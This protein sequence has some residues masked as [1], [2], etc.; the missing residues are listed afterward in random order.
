MSITIRPFRFTP[1]LSGFAVCSV[2]CGALFSP[3]LVAQEGGEE[4]AE[5]VLEVVMVTGSRIRRQD[6]VS[7]SP[8][9]T[10]SEEDL[11]IDGSL[12][13]GE[14]LQHLPSVGSSLNSNG[15]AGTSH[16]ARS[17]NLRSLGANRSLV[18][19][20]GHRWVNGAG[21]RGF[22]DFVDLNTIPQVMIESVEVLQDGASAIYG[23][24]AIAGVVNMRTY[25]NF[26]GSRVRAYYGT[27]SEADRDTESADLLLGKTFGSSNWMLAVSYLNED[28]IFTQDRKL[29]AIPL[30]GLSVGTPEG[31]FREAGLAGILPFPVPSAGITR[32]PGTDGSVISNW[33]AVN[34]STDRFNRFNN[35]Y[36]VA[37]NELTSVFLQNLTEFN[38]SVAFRLEALYNK[39]ESD[40][41]FSGAAPV[42]LGGSRGFIIANDPRVNPFG[43]PFAG[44]DFRI[45][46]FF[47][48]NGQRD[49]VQEV[50]T[51]R[52]GA[53]LEGDLAN[54][55]FWDSF[56]SYAKNEATFT[57]INQID[58]DKL[59]LG[60]RACD[61]TGITT[62]ITDL[63]AGCVP[64]NM[65]NPWTAEM[66]NYVNFTGLDENEAEQLD[67]TLNITGDITELPAGSL[68]F[69]A[70]YE[71]RKE[72][73]LDVPDSYINGS[74]RVNTFRT[75]TS[76]PRDGT[77]G[78]YDLNEIYLELNIP[79]LSDRAGVE[80]FSIQLASRYS[81]YSTFGST[82]NNKAGFIFRP[83]DSLMFRGTWAQGFRAPSIL[84]LFEGFRETSVPV[85]DPCSENGG[86][87]NLPGCAGIPAN[88]SQLASNAP[89]T[90][91]GNPELQPETSENLSFGF[92]L[93]PAALEGAS[94]T[95]DWY[96]I[97]LDDTIS[98][99]GAQ[100]LL[101]LCSSSG[102]RC[103]FITREP[104]GE[105]ANVSDG[106]INLN[107]TKV[108]GYDIV[109]RYALDSRFGLV[110]LSVSVSRL[111]DFT[112]QSTLNDGSILVDEKTGT[113][114]LREAYPKWKSL[115][116]LKWSNDA[117]SALYSWRYIDSTVEQ[118]GGEDRKIH[119]MTYHSLSGSY[120]FKDS[121]GFRLGVD[122]L[123]DRQPPS[124]LTNT[125]IN[126]DVS[127]YNAIGRFYYAQVTWDI[128]I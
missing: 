62:D 70:G 78:E 30:N 72:K 71:Y 49:N 53:G 88:Y 102:Q 2:L 105:L 108:E 83:V 9:Q 52:I 39:R 80:E 36:L 84:E 41:L 43:I 82:T 32:D 15:S 47:E 94:L 7:S 81:D 11:R 4:D 85:I 111:L 86:N 48:D 27:S 21:T 109:G 29:S 115:T 33:R 25:Q 73:G 6:E 46:N 3:L 16:G 63:L 120:E 113:T 45:D 92:V 76:A 99:F 112:E 65:F 95:V 106:P 119:S 97:R 17:L 50:E 67:F 69:A 22:R 13:L 121:W 59:A 38:N 51:Y 35:N 114:R 126:F 57:S 77:D 28:P 64:V 91:G 123:F 100:N 116:N 103:D 118:A 68:A 122:N 101:N 90:V 1:K 23:A 34:S 56:F 79:I 5:L 31:L 117:W 12:T 55:W 128:E 24:D 60:M 87:P 37:P 26:E 61:P 75:T 89:A 93:T 14:T 18:L 110:D 19:V 96:N 104:S 42:F 125:N 8:V 74:P 98:S 20:N 107:S 58:L 127:T 10:L 66:V 124:S 54:G 40:Q 44:S